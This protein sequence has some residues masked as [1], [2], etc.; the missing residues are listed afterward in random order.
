MGSLSMA[1]LEKVS[2]GSENSLNLLS[3]QLHDGIGR[4]AARKQKRQDFSIEIGWRVNRDLGHLSGLQSENERSVT[5]IA[6]MHA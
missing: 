1:M 5:L 3:E 6:L 2:F 4:N